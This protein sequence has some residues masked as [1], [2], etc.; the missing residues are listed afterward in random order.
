MSISLCSYT[1]YLKSTKCP[2]WATRIYIQRKTKFLYQ[3]YTQHPMGL[4][5]SHAQFLRFLMLFKLESV[6]MILRKV[7][8]VFKDQFFCSL[9]EDCHLFSFKNIFSENLRMEHLLCVS[10]FTGHCRF[11]DKET[12]F[13]TSSLVEETCL[14]INTNNNKARIEE[15]TK[16]QENLGEKKD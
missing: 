4:S 6:Q 1:L 7:M 14:K 5:A 3:F 16:L 10:H 12:L 2:V 11:G 8:W 15:C 13:L 9:Q